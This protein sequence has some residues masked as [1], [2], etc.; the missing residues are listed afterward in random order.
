RPPRCPMSWQGAGI[1]ALSLPDARQLS[2]EVLQALRLRALHG[3][4]MGFTETQMADIL[5]V[6]RQTVSRWWSA[7]AADGLAALP[8]ER[9]GRPPGSGRTLSNEQAAH[10]QQIIDGHR[11]EEL[12]I[13][14][15]LWTRRAACD[16]IRR[17]YGIHMSVH[18]VG[19][20]LRR[21]DYTARRPVFQHLDRDDA[22]IKRW[23]RRT[24]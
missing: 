19:R 3:C 24:F 12:G 7:Y 18:T 4:E 2:D 16:L 22:A 9:R 10:L 1:M 14:V 8:H 23:V 17:E 20:Y 15:P 21:W 13:G 5:G 11:P 6:A